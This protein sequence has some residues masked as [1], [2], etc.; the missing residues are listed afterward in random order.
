VALTA[1]HYNLEEIP[2]LIKYVEKELGA[3]KAIVFNFIPVRKGRE[4]ID[5]DLTPDERW[6]LLEDLYSKLLDENNSMTL[7]STA[8][9]YAAVSW[10]FAHGPAIATH[11]TNQAS[12]EA[13]RGRTKA[14]AQFLGG[15]GAGTL[16]CALE[17]NGDVEPCVFIPITI[18]NIKDQPLGWIWRN[19]EVLEKIRNRDEFEG[20]GDC[21][22]KYICGGCRARAYAYYGDLQGP[23]PSCPENEK[24][25][26]KLK[27]KT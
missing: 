9:Q 6:S 22:Y 13:L 21:E 3:K 4:I 8:P 11:F 10:E 7:Y 14:L 19:S 18:G 23:D 26:G 15:C 2:E 12:M 5:Q 1:T 24:Y 17:P 25:W 20:C 27:N 16:Y